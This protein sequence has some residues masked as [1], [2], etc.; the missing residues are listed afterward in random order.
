[1]LEAYQS[2]RDWLARKY[3]V[4]LQSGAVR[5]SAHSAGDGAVL[6]RELWHGTKQAD[7][8]QVRE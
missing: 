3:A 1:M 8:R 6:E 2:Q 7:P 4:G 5:I